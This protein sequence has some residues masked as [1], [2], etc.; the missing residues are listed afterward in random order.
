[1]ALISE[2]VR[3]GDGSIK[4]FAVLGE[5]PSESHLRVWLD[6]VQVG[7]SDWD[8]L[9][10]MVIFHTAP[11]GNLV[12]QT[13][14]TGTEETASPSDIATVAT[15]I[16]SVN[17]VS[18]SIANV[19]TVSDD[20]ANVN[21]VAGIHYAVSSVANNEGQIN[22][23]WEDLM[24][25]PNSNI[26][27]VSNDLNSK[28]VPSKIIPVS[29]DL[30]GANTIGA[31][32][33]SIAN[34]NTT[35]T[36]IANINTVATN[37][38]GVNTV[39]TD[40]AK[41]IKVAD[42]LSEAIS[43][44]ETVAN[45]LNETTSEIDTV[46]NSIA[47]VDAVGS[48]IASV[49][50]VHGNEANINAVHANATNINTV[51]SDTV[52]INEIYANRVEIYQ[53][54]DNAQ[55]ATTQAGI[56]TTKA[57]EAS[58]SATNA[59][60]SLSTF[61]GQYVS[62][63]TAPTSPTEGMLWFDTTNDLMKVYDGTLWGLAGSSVNG[64]SERQTYVATSGQT[65]FNATYDVGYV[66]VYLNGIKLVP[67]TDFTATN[68]TTVVLSSGANTGDIV[69][70]V[71][72]GTFELADTYTQAQADSLLNAK[73]NVADVP[74]GANSAIT[75]D[76]TNIA[77]PSGVVTVSSDDDNYTKIESNSIQF[78]NTIVNAQ[79]FINLLNSSRTLEISMKDSSTIK[80][81]ILLRDDGRVSLPQGK[82]DLGTNPL[83]ATEI[84][85]A[86]D[87]VA[88]ITPPKKGGYM[89]IG[90]K[91]NDVYPAG[92]NNSALIYYDCGLSLSIAKA[93]IGASFAGSVNV[94]T[95]NVTGT[96]G[97]DGK[98]TV[99]VQSNVVKIE[100]RSGSTQPYNI[101]FL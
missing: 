29:E 34:V 22:V 83:G 60:T 92:G 69:D 57:T 33:S 63:A 55:T 100:N 98:Q 42:D 44:V 90:R 50:A 81:S 53:A 71:A 16:I 75:D 59:A 23:V 84:S 61:T 89:I 66:D 45:D 76:G 79:G 7:S 97:T 40:I 43:E 86:D 65:T 68:G 56:A 8:L 4:N 77:I 54:D 94:S 62:Q 18:S 9:G 20:I 12:I 6:N 95:S 64:T 99:A 32:A 51:S 49:V 74:N 5:I 39:A 91:W 3:V 88:T 78:F 19:D 38:G 73:A 14:E 25:I 52:A 41:V 31:V 13:Y 36:A 24:L 15:N 35:A 58:T 10:N 37:I 47:N 48:N 28:Y 26:I 67:T 82:F 72:Y 87:S 96:T 70:I 11:T 85:I 2:T 46:A 21:T 93:D 1:M 30:L 27:T 80:S 101:V 17:N